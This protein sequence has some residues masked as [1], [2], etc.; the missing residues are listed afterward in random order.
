MIK[1]RPY[2]QQSSKFHKKHQVLTCEV[3]FE[4][5]IPYLLLVH[6]F[7]SFNC[8]SR[9]KHVE[10][11]S[12]FVFDRRIKYNKTTLF[13]STLKLYLRKDKDLLITVDQEKNLTFIYFLRKRDGSQSSHIRICRDAFLKILCLK[14]DRVLGVMKIHHASGGKIATETRKLEEF[15]EKK[16][17]LWLLLQN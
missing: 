1:L 2:Q 12:V 17:K 14:K 10:H 11:A 8:S 3:V 6:V 13:S 9:C 5:P 15:A 4:F 16:L 7:L